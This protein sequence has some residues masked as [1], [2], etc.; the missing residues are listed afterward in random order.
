MTGATTITIPVGNWDAESFANYINLTLAIPNKLV[1]DSARLKY[2]FTPALV[3]SAGTTCQDLLGITSGSTGTFSE[4][5]QPVNF[6][7]PTQINLETNLSLFNVPISNRLISIPVDVNYGE[8]LRYID[9]SSSPV[10]VLDHVVHVLTIKLTDQNGDE[11][12]TYDDIPWFVDL[13]VI[14]QQDE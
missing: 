11:L 8:Y 4:S 1:Y 2:I 5:N 7:G 14:L 9:Q 3:V 13:E 10:L 6:S 12:D